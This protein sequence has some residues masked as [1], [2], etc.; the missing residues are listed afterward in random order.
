MSATSPT[1]L[2]SIPVVK[3][4]RLRLCALDERHMDDLA[5]IGY[6]PAVAR[7]L[8]GV[9][10]PPLSLEQQREEIW[11]Y[12]AMMR[13]HWTMRG[14]GQW[15]VERHSDGT[16]LGR[17]G[18]WQPHGWPGIEVGWMIGPAFQRQGYA[19]EGAEAAL[20]FAFTAVGNAG[21]PLQEVISLT[22]ADNV[23]S[24]GVMTRI[25]MHHVDDVHVRGHDQVRYLISREQWRR[26]R[27]RQR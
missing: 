25:G 14:F 9:P 20:D 27:A 23:A 13:G 11:R 17:V 16:L 21:A 24:R 10:D 8:G 1:A 18:L 15:A 5:A 19:T 4:A 12:I 3:T 6:D 2:G 7:W 26:R 22:V